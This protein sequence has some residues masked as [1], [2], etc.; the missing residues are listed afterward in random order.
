M[1]VAVI[2]SSVEVP[3]AA[4]LPA[5][6]PSDLRLV[7]SVCC[8]CNEDHSE[9]CAVGEDFEYRTS[10]DTFVAMRC[11]DCGLIYLSPRPDVSEL[12]R[13]YPPSYHAFNFSAEQF[14]F[15]YRVRRWLEGRRLTSWCQGLPD[16]ARILDVG[17]GDGFHLD[18][19]R[20]YGKP[21]WRLE[22]VDMSERAVA[23]A[24]A[25]GLTVI[26]GSIESA[27][28]D[29]AA[30]DLVILIQTI[31][32][33]EQPAVTLRAIRE[34]LRPG[35]RLVIVTDNTGSLDA[36]LFGGRHWGGY[37][38]PR[39]WNLFNRDAMRR[40]AEKVGL[41]VQSIKTQVSPVNWVYSFRNLLVDARAPRWLY[42]RFSLE[43]PVSLAV[44]TLLDQV[45]TA[46]GNGAL[47]RAVLRRPASA[48]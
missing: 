40:L 42:N 18:L 1:S 9:P 38:F 37:H 23:V 47:L 13:I 8:V 41:E 31:E 43:S 7:P 32:H 10:R 48:E 25:K 11:Q 19:L 34:V 22:G 2:D 16:H 36:K 30:Y 35:G 39:H 3:H 14:G 15:V 21:T 5:D 46:S 33:I 24:R 20:Q 45:F 29:R 26:Q 44:F 4:T 6:A 28:V 12:S 17:C 27:N